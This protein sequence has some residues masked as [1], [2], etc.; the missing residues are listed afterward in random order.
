MSPVI[1][2]TMMI[3]S[4]L[5]GAMVDRI[6]WSIICKKVEE[7]LDTITNPELPKPEAKNTCAACLLR[8]A[9]TEDFVLT[10]TT[11]LPLLSADD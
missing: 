10:D 4:F 11:I 8:S 6:H 2:A 7:G 3:A 5:S 1:L 9:T